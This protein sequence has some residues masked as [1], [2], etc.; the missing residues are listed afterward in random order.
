MTHRISVIVLSGI[1]ILAGSAMAESSAQSQ[2]AAIPEGRISP[3]FEILYDLGSKIRYEADMP[4]Y[5]NIAFDVKRK[6]A[7]AQLSY[8]DFLLSGG[9]THDA[10]I[11]P[12]AQMYYP[13]TMESSSAYGYPRSNEPEDPVGK[14]FMVSAGLRSIIWEQNRLSIQ[15]AG[16]LTYRRETYDATATY[17]SYPVYAE[18]SPEIWP[19]PDPQPQPTTYSETYNIDMRG[20]ELSAGLTGTITGKRYTVY[21]GMELQAYSDLEADVTVT[22]ADGASHSEKSNMDRSDPVTLLLGLKATF[23][24]TYIL[25]ETRVLGESSLRV[26]ASLAF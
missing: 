10:R 6:T 2:A 21:A 18:A 20:T 17:I 13:M 8:G 4:G 11:E 22:N 15:A 1:V 3:S 19:P 25:V 7:I 24:Q 12:K 9:V 26:G 23:N 16:Q 14:G 5:G